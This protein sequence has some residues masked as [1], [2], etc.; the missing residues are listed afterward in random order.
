MTLVRY[1]ARAVAV[2][3]SYVWIAAP[4]VEAYVTPAFFTPAFFTPVARES[5]FAV[6]VVVYVVSI[7]PTSTLH[8]I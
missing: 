7:A 6:V 1:C 2:V 3:V 5:V 4:T 8:C